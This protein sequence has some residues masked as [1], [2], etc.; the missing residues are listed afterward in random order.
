MKEPA[1]VESLRLGIEPVRR[2]TRNSVK[3]ADAERK[4]LGETVKAAHAGARFTNMA[5]SVYPGAYAEA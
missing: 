4:R 2:H 5:S 1:T 3:F